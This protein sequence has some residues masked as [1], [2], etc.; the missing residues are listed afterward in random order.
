MITNMVS[1]RRGLVVT[2]GLAPDRVWF[3]YLRGRFDVVVAADSGLMTAISVGVPVD[4]VV[5]D[6]DSLEDYEMLS[7]F[8]PESVQVFSTE[9]DFTDTEIGLQTLKE[10]GCTS[11]TIYGGGGGR[12]DHLIGILTLFERDNPPVLWVSDSSVAIFIDTTICTD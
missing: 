6:M 1:S 5:G 4:R 10:M 8:P 12:L 9:K 11:T 2:G 7:V 3:D